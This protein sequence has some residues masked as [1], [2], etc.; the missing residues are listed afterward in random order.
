MYYLVQF[1]GFILSKKHA[2]LFR[3]NTSYYSETFQD[4]LLNSFSKFIIILDRKVKC[5]L[6][7][8]PNRKTKSRNISKIL[9]MILILIKPQVN[10]HFVQVCQVEKALFLYDL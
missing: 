5:Q 1:G 6:Y 3:R 10:G 2:C 8:K 4:R 9:F 7:L